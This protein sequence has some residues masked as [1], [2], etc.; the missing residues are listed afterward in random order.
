MVKIRFLVVLRG[1]VLPSVVLAVREVWPRVGRYEGRCL[2]CH[3]GCL[4]ISLHPSY[5]FAFSVNATATSTDHR[6]LGSYQV[7][8]CGSTSIESVH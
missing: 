1:L 8:A 5:H 3:G 4:S 2:Y 6:D 7:Q